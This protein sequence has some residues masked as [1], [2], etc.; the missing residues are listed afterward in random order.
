MKEE[1]SAAQRSAAQ[2]AQSVDGAAQALSGAGSEIRWHSQS[3]RIPG[4]ALAAAD[5]SISTC[6]LA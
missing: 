3:R 5:A 6:S 1:R 4:E 2:R